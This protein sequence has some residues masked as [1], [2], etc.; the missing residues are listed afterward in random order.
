MLC[1]L[2]LSWS[3]YY[4]RHDH[5]LK[6]H[7]QNLEASKVGKLTKLEWGANLLFAVGVTADAKTGCAAMQKNQ[8]HTVKRRRKLLARQF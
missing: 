2:A 6:P 3:I 1:W 4:S 8:V 7:R 5:W